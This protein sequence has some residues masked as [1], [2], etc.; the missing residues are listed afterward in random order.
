MDD[1][2]SVIE[3]VRGLPAL[4]LLLDGDGRIRDASEAWCR[5][6]GFDRDAVRGHLPMDLATPESARRI[7]EEHRPRFRRT[8]RLI[9]VPVEFVSHT[10]EVVPVIANTRARYGPDGLIAWSITI[11]AELSDRYRLER[12]YRDLYQSTPAM[13]HTIDP[14]GRLIE[15]S[16]YWLAKLGY[17]RPEVM[18]RSVLDF[19]GEESRRGLEGRLP[20]VIDEPDLQDAP[21]QVLRRNGEPLEL[22]M[23]TRTERDADGRVLRRLV[24]SVDVTERNRA[25]AQLKE[26]YAEIARLKDELERERDYLREE[27]RGAMNAGRIVGDSPAL[28]AMLERIDAVA[29][30]NASVLII[31]ETGTGKELVAHAIH[32]R[33]SRASHPLVK[34]NCASIPQELFES[35]FF[36]HVRG[37]FT[38]ASRD[39]PGRFQLADGGTIFLDE[40]GEIPMSLQGKLLRV[41]QER[42]FERVGDDQTQTV[43][44]RVIAATNKDLEQAV[45]A[46]QFREDLYYRL[47]VFPV[48]VPPL[49]RRG[50]D[51]V[52]LAAHFLE[53]ACREFG[54]PVLALTPAQLDALRA[55]D[56]PGNVRELRNVIERAVIL[57][58]DNELLLDLP[59]A[60]RTPVVTV[61]P[62]TSSPP[63]VPAAPARTLPGPPGRVR[64]EAQLRDEQRANIIAALEA[65]SWRVSGHGG[66]A[67]LLGLRPTTLADR[68]RRLGIRRPVA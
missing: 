60:G 18:G 62:L 40:V 59:V 35:E 9:D 5:R 37:A 54:R 29:A 30:T 1:I 63:P 36:G 21:R 4:A 58:R 33:S 68:M 8:G 27:V 46:G 16:D 31:G 66:A 14:E 2:A 53:Q 65:A 55:Y 44:V 26:A 61:R 20:Q 48:S 28:A 49:R 15:V 56:W 32:A 24:A 51:V 11:F 64:T 39:R 3:V 47:S 12:R 13:L 10:G 19:L 45:E 23:S 25:E 22:L 17:A 50:E 57:S 34:V 41:L 7:D 42:Q 43:D 38:G 67:E 6:L 52:Q